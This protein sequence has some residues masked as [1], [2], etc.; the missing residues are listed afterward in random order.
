LF[1]VEEWISQSQS[2]RLHCHHELFKII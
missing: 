2:H 1:K